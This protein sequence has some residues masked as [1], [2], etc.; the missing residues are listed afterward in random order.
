[1]GYWKSPTIMGYW[2]SPTIMG[3]WKSPT[4]KAQQSSSP[5]LFALSWQRHS[6]SL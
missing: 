2:K 5:N 4:G 3:Y 6:P 1:M